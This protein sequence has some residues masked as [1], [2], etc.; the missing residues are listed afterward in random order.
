MRFE[1]LDH[2]PT[3]DFGVGGERIENPGAIPLHLEH[4]ESWEFRE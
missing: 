2:C 4:R 1:P 3:R